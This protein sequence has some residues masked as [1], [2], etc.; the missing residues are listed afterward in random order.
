MYGGI[1]TLVQTTPRSGAEISVVLRENFVVPESVD[2]QE[3]DSH[4]VDKVH[5]RQGR[6][7][8]RDQV[9]SAALPKA[10]IVVAEPRLVVFVVQR[11]LVVMVA[12]CLMVLTAAMTELH[13]GRRGAAMTDKSEPE[14]QSFN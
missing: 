13:V 5:V 4:V 12:A 8:V 2:R 14:I 7:V 11:P 3:V 1:L 6:H 10:G 9:L